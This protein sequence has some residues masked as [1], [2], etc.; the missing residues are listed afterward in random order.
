M[1]SKLILSVVFS[2]ILSGFLTSQAFA[3]SDIDVVLPENNI[4]SEDDITDYLV[5]QI[6]EDTQTYTLD[7][8]QGLAMINADINANATGDV[9][10]ICLNLSTYEESTIY[11]YAVNGYKCSEYLDAGTYVITD[12]GVVGDKYKTYGVINQNFT[13]E[14]QSSINVTVEVRGG[15]TAATDN[16][17]ENKESVVLTIDP[18]YYENLKADVAENQENTEEIVEENNTNPII[19]Y[20]ILAITIIVF[21]VLIYFAIKN[22]KNRR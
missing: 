3:K 14:N 13:V 20:V 5:D 16:A 8:G 22:K 15:E 11:M 12:G 7:Y 18:D 4:V 9:Y 17:L 1:K 2:V 21:I 6:Q 19:T 10:I